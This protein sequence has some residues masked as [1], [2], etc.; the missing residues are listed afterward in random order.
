MTTGQSTKMVLGLGETSTFTLCGMLAELRASSRRSKWPSSGGV[1]AL[2]A[3]LRP[4][5]PVRQRGL[6]NHSRGVPRHLQHESTGQLLR[7]RCHG[8]LLL[9]GQKRT[10]GAIRRLRDR[11]SSCSIPSRCS[12]SSSVVTR[13]SAR[14]VR[15]PSSETLLHARQ[16]NQPVHEIGSS[17]PSLVRHH[18]RRPPDSRS[19]MYASMNSGDGAALGSRKNLPILFL[20]SFSH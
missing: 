5:Q 14:S 20:L 8:E 3:S 2:A 15:P 18:Q 9:D 16:H 1:R 7:Q 19:L 4:R 6:P 12:I 13:P 10:R 11:E 17:P